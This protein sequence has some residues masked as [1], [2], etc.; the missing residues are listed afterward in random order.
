MSH[1]L[2]PHHMAQALFMVTR[3]TSQ[4]ET[5]NILDALYAYLVLRG[6]VHL[7]PDIV[8]AYTECVLKDEQGEKVYVLSKYSLDKKQLD[9]LQVF[10]KNRF[11]LDQCRLVHNVVDDALGGISIRYRDTVLD[12][13]VDHA[14]QQLSDQLLQS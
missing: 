11:N 1:R 4:K 12:M 6:K 8:E 9:R 14:L 5:Q 7:L 3:T 10:I 2:D 13:S